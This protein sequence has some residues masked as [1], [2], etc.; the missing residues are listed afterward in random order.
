VEQDILTI[1]NYPAP[2]L[3]KKARAV[4]FF[5]QRLEEL[6][7]KMLKTMYHAPGIG[8]A[9]PQVGIGV[10]IFVLDVDYEKEKVTV[11]GQEKL[12]LKNF[13]PKVFINPN[14]TLSPEKIETEEGCLSLPGINELVQRSKTLRIDFQDVKGNHQ[15]LEADGLLSI[16]IQHE[17]DH[18]EGK[19]FLDRLSLLKKKL[20][21]KKL[22]KKEKEDNA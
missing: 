2:I 16:C 17:F 14:L 8:L 11:H 20:L 18:L 21:R 7:A 13:N 1:V 22:L 5:D 9:A 12:I 15:S 19:V 10:R 6:T 4:E 3:A